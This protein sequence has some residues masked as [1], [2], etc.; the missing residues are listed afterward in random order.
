MN[1]Q[2][3]TASVARLSVSQRLIA[4]VLAL[5]IGFVLV[6]GVGFAS[7]MAIHNGAHDT[8]HALGFPCH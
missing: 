6:G 4:G 1:T 7:D 5:F 8:R 2:V 3:Q